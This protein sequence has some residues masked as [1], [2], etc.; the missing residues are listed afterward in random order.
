M[1]AVLLSGVTD[2]AWAQQPRKVAVLAFENAGSF[3]Q[4]T[5]AAERLRLQLPALFAS[6]LGRH[7]GL[8]V[9]D[10]S[11]AGDRAG[12]VDVARAVQHARDAGA[13]YAVTGNFVDHFGRFRLNVE[14]VD[15]ESGA[16]VKVVS[17]DDRALQRRE[18]LQRIVQME[19]ARIAELLTARP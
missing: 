1:A 19:A 10:R 11:T 6:E 13:R 8:T 9:V 16:I 18:D 15:G 12:H 2:P 3:G 7:P 5:A 17:N 4:D 14:I